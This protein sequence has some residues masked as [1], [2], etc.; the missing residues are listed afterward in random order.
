MNRN[1]KIGDRM[2]E[3]YEER[4]KFRLTR[5]TPVIIRLDG[6][7]FHT[8]TKGFEK[9]FDEVLT[10][11][12][13]ATML[14]LCQN[15]QGCIYGYTQSDEITLVLIDYKKLES[16][17]WF[18]YEIQ[19][20]CSVA[21]SMATLQ[22]NRIFTFFATNIFIDSP[23]QQ[24]YFKSLEKGAMFDARCF[25]IPKEE[26]V[27]CL[28]WRQQDAIRNSINSCGQ[29]HFSH[30]ELKGKSCEQILQML[31]EEKDF[32]WNDLPTHLQRGI[33]CTKKTEEITTPNGEKTIRS[34]WIVGDE[35]P[36]FIGEER[37]NIE[38]LIFI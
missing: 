32:D 2:K 26:V 10:R 35:T 21:A 12:M 22:F 36:I 25:N 7:S 24:E 6:K 19:K 5:R 3:F 17:A 34:R 8:F 31:K 4:S 29:A 28:Y 15:I 23:K 30:K 18:D 13:E 27:N 37:K 20:L 9:P 14:F 1:K 33:V 38:D 16:D 11:T